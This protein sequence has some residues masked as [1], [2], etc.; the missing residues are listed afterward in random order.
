VHSPHP[1]QQVVLGLLREPL[2]AKL[3][4]QMREVLSPGAFNRQFGLYLNMGRQ[5]GHTTLAAMILEDIPGS[6]AIEPNERMVTLLRNKVPERADR[7]VLA[8]FPDTQMKFNIIHRVEP[9]L[10]EATVCVVDGASL[11][12][13]WE[14]APIRCAQWEHYVELG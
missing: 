10:S 3:R 8:R 6:I 14:V 2:N 11:L 4:D 5:A 9:P 1:W 12:S 13:E 7:V